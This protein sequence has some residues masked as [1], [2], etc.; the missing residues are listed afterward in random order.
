MDDRD[1]VLEPLARRLRDEGV[2]PERDLWPAIDAAISRREGLGRRRPLRTWWSAAAAA[3][4]LV[5][6]LVTL[7]RPEGPAAPEPGL[8]ASA[9]R[10]GLDTV[11]QALGDLEAALAAD[12]DN[13]SLARLVLM[14]H[15]TRGALLQRFPTHE[16]GIG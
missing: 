13:L 14:V 5:G 9:A 12:P 6:L 15:R 11:D 2:P 10:P 8:V 4:L 1:P 16:P 3:A 7:P